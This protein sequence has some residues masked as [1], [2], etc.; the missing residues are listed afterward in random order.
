MHTSQFLHS[1]RDSR[2]L[3]IC[4]ANASLPAFAGSGH[5]R[6]NID[7][8][9]DDFNFLRIYPDDGVIFV[10]RIG[11]TLPYMGL[12]QNMIVYDYI[13]KELITTR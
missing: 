13:N 4:V 5:L 2:Q 11:S 6:G 10:N 1:G 3:L 12:R 9:R 8:Y 7:G